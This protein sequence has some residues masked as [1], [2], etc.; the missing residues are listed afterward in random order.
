MK[1]GDHSFQ[2][3]KESKRTREENWLIAVRL[4]GRF[5]MEQTNVELAVR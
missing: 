1:E 4:I 2:P 3:P 5:I